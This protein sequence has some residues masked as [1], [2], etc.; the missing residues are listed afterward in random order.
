MSACCPLAPCPR[1]AQQPGLAGPGG[2]QPEV[3]RMRYSYASS[4]PQIIQYL[5]LI[6]FP[7]FICIYPLGL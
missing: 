1:S 2:C 5:L 6:I 7:S 3:E 4:H